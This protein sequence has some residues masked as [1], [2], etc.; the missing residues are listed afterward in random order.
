VATGTLLLTLLGLPASAQSIRVSPAAVNVS[1]Q[2]GTV[3]LLTFGPLQS[4]VPAEACWC[5]ELT[6]AAPDTGLRCDPA[7]IFGCLPSRYNQSVGSGTGGFTDIMAIPPS[8]V[9]RAY[10]AAE[11]GTGSACTIRACTLSSTTFRSCISGRARSRS[12][13]PVS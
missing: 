2:S 13:W 4:F 6:S 5:G 7:T 9:R 10:Q 3:H 11:E 8:V 12:C 1:S